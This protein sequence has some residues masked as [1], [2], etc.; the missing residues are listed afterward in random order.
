M[1][2]EKRIGGKNVQW[3]KELVEKMSSGKNGVE[4][5]GYNLLNEIGALVKFQS[6]KSKDDP[7]FKFETRKANH[8]EIEC[9]QS[10]NN[11]D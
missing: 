5:M 7:G 4:K 2:V 8:S 10:W 6:L 1:G 9:A 11:P 3:K